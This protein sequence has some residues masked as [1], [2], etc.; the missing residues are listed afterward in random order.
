MCTIV[1]LLFS[2]A[3]AGDG[4]YHPN[5]LAPESAEFMRLN[6]Q[7]M[8][9]FEDRSRTS[10]EIGRSLALYRESLDLLGNLAPDDEYSR[11]DALE[12]QY[13]RER[14]VLETFANTLVDDVDTTFLAALDKAKTSLGVKAMECEREIQ[15]GPQ[16]PGM[17]GRTE[18]NPACKG[19]DLN[20]SLAKA[21]DA[22]PEL[23]AVVAEIIALEWPT[24]GIDTEAQSAVGDGDGWIWIRPLFATGAPQA[25]RAI[26]DADDNARLPFQAAL[27]DEPTAPQLKQL[28]EAAEGVTQTTAT[29]RAN[30]AAPVLVVADKALAKMGA[31]AAWCANPPSLGGCTGDNKTQDL[32]QKLVADGKVSKTLTKAAS[33]L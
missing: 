4:F 32:V 22:D 2:T 10:A 6:E 13:N 5:D 12:K 26:D 18:P 9:P 1:A 30:L 20:A 23:Q 31:S 17:R 16:V 29:S 8:G 24:F 19:D 14:A 3:F 28:T 25:L 15:V 7:A 11:L 27:E 33:A 21:M